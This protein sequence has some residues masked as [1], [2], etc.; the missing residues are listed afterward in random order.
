MDIATSAV[1]KV[2]EYLVDPII[3]PFTYCCTYNTNFEKLNN[4]VDKLKIA[5]ASVQYKVEDSRIKGDGI[6]HHVEKWMITVDKA[7]NEVE[8]LIADKENSNNRWLKGLCPNL[9]TRYQLSM[10]AESEANAIAGLLEKGRFDG[11]S[12]RT[13]PEETWLNSTEGFMHFES[14]TST[15]KEILDALSNRNFNMIGVYGMGG[16]GKTTL[17]KEVGRQAK[18]YNLFEKVIS[19][20]VSRTPQIK[21]IQREIA[22]KIG[23]ELAEQSHETVR[24]GRLLERLKKD[25]KILIILDDIW[26]SLA[27]EA[28]G[29]PLADDIG[30]CKVLLT[31][32]SHDVLSS[33]MDC[34]KNIFV[35]VLNAKEAWSLFRKM[36]GDCIENGELKSVATEIVKECAGLPIAIVPVAKALKNKSS[37]YVWKDA[38]RQLKNKSFLGPAYSSLELS[39]YHL[40]G[41]D[42]EGEELRKTFLLIGYSF[43]SCVEDVIYYGM[44]LGLFQN[45]NTLE[46]ARDRAHTLVDKLKN[47]CLLLDGWRSGWFSMHDVV[48]DVAISI[49]SRVQHVFAV[50]NEVVPPT[51]W[52][53]EDALK[54][55]TAISLKNSNISEPPQGFE[56]PQLKFLCIE[57]HASLRIPDNFFTGM[58]EL[59]VLDF[60]QMQY[61]L[62]LPSSLGLLQNLQTLSLDFCKLGDIAIIGDLKKL[63]ILTFRGSDMKELVGEIGQLT[64]LRLYSPRCLIELIPIRRTIYW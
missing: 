29:I 49:A 20:H 15:L 57:Y 40:E 63:V 19:A 22:E 12:F 3:H 7:I 9:K 6:Q 52:P 39:Y 16:I 10:K 4:E 33:K 42:L 36:T 28:I 60:T 5:R 45:I 43:I 41:E 31:A 17:V 8:T 64:Q 54:V 48:R 46:E 59:R 50:E 44:G 61:L 11:V 34:Q 26:G 1:A 35:D 21:E 55:C 14:R 56:C 13:I 18:E 38:L 23:L 27:L 30:G 2:A 53:D 37:L 58:T 51:S 24:A 62:V 32:R 25:T 47:S